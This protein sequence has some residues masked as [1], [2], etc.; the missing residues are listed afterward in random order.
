[1]GSTMMTFNNKIL[2]EEMLI[3]RSREKKTWNLSMGWNS[4]LF[5]PSIIAHKKKLLPSLRMYAYWVVTMPF[6][7]IFDEL[8]EMKTKLCFPINP[9]SEHDVDLSQPSNAFRVWGWFESRIKPT[10]TSVCDPIL[11]ENGL[12]YYYDHV[13]CIKAFNI[14]VLCVLVLYE[15]RNGTIKLG[16]KY[17][18]N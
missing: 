14:Y 3:K 10:S 7:I 16:M 11:P 6:L 18:L 5:Y 2:K 1:M 15:E 13:S 8:K 17:A 4:W 9:H 12:F